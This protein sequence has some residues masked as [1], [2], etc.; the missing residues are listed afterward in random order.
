[1]FITSGSWSWGNSINTN[2][3]LNPRVPKWFSC[4][5]EST[6][7]AKKV[8]SD[9]CRRGFYISSS[10]CVLLSVIE[11]QHRGSCSARANEIGVRVFNTVFRVSL[12][13]PVLSTRWDETLPLLLYHFKKC[14]KRRILDWGRREKQYYAVLR[15][16]F[17][18]NN[19]VNSSLQTV[20]SLMISQ[21]S[22]P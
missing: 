6:A 20:I 11:F 15:F 13:S 22:S 8:H 9:P 21:K 12:I 19:N 3:K 10:H 16:S 2:L 7:A 1:M 4:Q 5:R 18:H 14:T 17:L